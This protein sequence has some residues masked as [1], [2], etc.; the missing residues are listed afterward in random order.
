MSEATATPR[1]NRPAIAV[2][3][4]THNRASLLRGAL[5]SLA[6]Q[7][8]PTSAFEVV[9]VDDGSV[10][11]TREV[12]SSV[13]GLP[14][15]YAFQRNTGIASARNHAIF[16][17]RA[18][19]LLFFDDDDVASPTLLRE[20]LNAHRR[21]SGDFY[22]VLGYT[23]LDAALRTDPLMNYCTN[24]AGLLFA[25][26]SLKGRRI[27]DFT[28]FWGGRSS[29]KRR[30]L[31]EHG[32]FNPAFRFGNEDIELGFR[33]SKRG[34]RVVYW[35]AATS[36]MVRSMTVNEFVNRTIRQGG[37]DAVFAALHRDALIAQLTGVDHA[38]NMWA[39]VETSFD[40]V[41]SSARRL[42]EMVRVKMRLG[43]PIEPAERAWLHHA[44]DRA[45]RAARMKGIHEQSTAAAASGEIRPFSLPVP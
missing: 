4:T 12:A 5:L 38:V 28:Y 6:E 3:I 39:Q 2:I 26:G 19:L 25:Y 35:P 44:Y 22:A 43:L 36:T 30:F 24:V 27:V 32:V 9:V 1:T 21:Y 8:V 11:D 18:P 14:V 16:L 41:I 33:L 13:P 31:L 23:E 10:D 29:C 34:F 40:A 37:S 45:F 42:D 20:H 15:R 7:T 17:T